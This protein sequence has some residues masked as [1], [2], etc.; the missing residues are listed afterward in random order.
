MPLRILLYV[1]LPGLVALL[2]YYAVKNSL[3][4]GKTSHKMHATIFKP[5]TAQKPVN[6]SA[7]PNKNRWVILVIGQSNA[8]NHGESMYLPHLSSIYS[9]YSGQCYLASNP[10]PG[11]SGAGGSFM[12]L[13]GK[14]LLDRAIADSVLFIPMA[15]ESTS[16]ADWTYNPILS[17]KIAQAAA[18]LNLRGIAITHL[19]WQQGEKDAAN[20]MLGKEYEDHFLSFLGRFR[21]E[22]ISA[23][24]YIAKA[25]Y[26]F[27]KHNAEIHNAQVG[28]PSKAPGLRPGPDADLLDSPEM[29]IESCHFSAIGLTRLAEMW[30]DALS[31]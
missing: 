2:A 6:C 15:I 1:L 31:K 3:G 5:G 30:A 26:C 24:V 13:L 8:A 11:A 27:G 19:L 25:S 4:S 18:D 12:P 14:L 7:I 28:L 16:V 17:N 10:M 21:K 23:P 29:R 9:Y 20:G 22:G